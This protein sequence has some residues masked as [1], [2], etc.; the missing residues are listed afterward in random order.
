MPGSSLAA[1]HAANGCALSTILAIVSGVQDERIAGG[2]ALFSGKLQIAVVLQNLVEGIEGFFPIRW[3]LQQTT[4]DWHRPEAVRV[5][6]HAFIK[7]LRLYR[8]CGRQKQNGF[9]EMHHEAGI[10]IRRLAATHNPKMTRTI[11][12][13]LEKPVPIVSLRFA[14]NQSA[15]EP[16]NAGGAKRMAAPCNAQ[17]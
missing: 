2:R 3:D 12:L 1:M 13:V 15:T 7:R 16:S 8:I 5:L 17:N 14:M 9:I 10:R 6:A 4:D 11:L